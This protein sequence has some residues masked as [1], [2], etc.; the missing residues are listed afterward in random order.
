MCGRLLPGTRVTE[1]DVAKELRV[2]RTPAREAL[3]RLQ[4]ERLLVPTGVRDGAKVRLAVAPITAAEAREL[5]TAVGALEGAVARN[6]AAC[7]AEARVALAV[8]LVRAQ[9]AFRREATRRAPDCDRLFELDHAFHEQLRAGLAGPRIRLLLDGLWSHLRRYAHFYGR[10]Q[11]ANF[12]ATFA[13]H[14]AIVAA[15]ESGNADAAERA[16]RANWLNGAD[17]LATIVERAGEARLLGGFASLPY[18]TAVATHGATHTATGARP[19]G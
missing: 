15:I 1:A 11:A 19:A 17:R 2:S 9:A 4:Q 6:V 14:D 18:P 8:E 7:D 3:R 12:A 5:G 16:V 10:H 13:E